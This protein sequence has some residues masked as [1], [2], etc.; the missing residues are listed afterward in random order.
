ML[1]IHRL[2]TTPA[3]SVT[4]T[5]LQFEK[6]SVMFN[7]V[8]ILTQLGAVQNLVSAEGLRLAADY[9]QVAYSLSN[10]AH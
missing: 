5:D 3:R 8:A 1:F 4:S 6:A 10:Q 7:V 2:L 9:F